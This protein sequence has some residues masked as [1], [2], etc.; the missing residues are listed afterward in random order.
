MSKQTVSLTL[1]G[2]GLSTALG[3]S[4]AEITDVSVADVSADA[5]E[6]THQGTS[7]AGASAF[8]TFEAS[9]LKNSG[10]FRITYFYNGEAVVIGTAVTGLTVVLE[11][12]V[13][14]VAIIS[15]NAFLQ[16]WSLTANM[17]ENMTAEATFKFTGTITI[18]A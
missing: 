1:T 12:G 8:R 3:T 16:D 17:G 5:I 18:G 2:T 14:D 11:R 15:G 13:T 10:T 9:I 7:T 6:T 4:S